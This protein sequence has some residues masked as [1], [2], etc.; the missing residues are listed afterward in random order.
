MPAPT[1]WL[2]IACRPDLTYIYKSF[3]DASA[4]AVFAEIVTGWKKWRKKFIAK[5]RVAIERSKTCV[6][7]SEVR[8]YSVSDTK[9]GNENW[10]SK[11]Q[12]AHRL[13]GRMLNATSF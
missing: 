11:D 12:D 4:C 7:T 1:N 9:A 5:H 6:F 3:S 10:V 8:P 2:A 13:F